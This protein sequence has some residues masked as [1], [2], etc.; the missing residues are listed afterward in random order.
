M[1]LSGT[2]WDITLGAHIRG[3]LELSSA[4][5]HL[6]NGFCQVTAAHLT[7]VWNLGIKQ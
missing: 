3:A 2:S 4:F 5:T 6:F 7:Q 1:A